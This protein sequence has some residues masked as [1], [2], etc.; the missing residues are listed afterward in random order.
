MRSNR[1]I[2]RVTV[3]GGVWSATTHEPDRIVYDNTSLRVPRASGR[4][5][6]PLINP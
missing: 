4:C 5:S 2:A 6:G 3:R 1:I